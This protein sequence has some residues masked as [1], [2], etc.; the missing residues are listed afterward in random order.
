M[1][2][3]SRIVS[4][5]ICLGFFVYG[6]IRV[7]VGTA[8]ILQVHSLIAVPDLDLAISDT[9]DFLARAND[10]AIIAS[11]VAPYFAYIITMGTVLIAGAIGAFRRR[12]WGFVLIGIYLAMHGALFVNFLTVNPKIAYLI[13]GVALLALLIFA[14]RRGYPARS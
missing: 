11:G 5:L 10:R 1:T 12:K 8:L 9:A 13:G 2:R 14:Q 7:G 3:L 6:V 4:L